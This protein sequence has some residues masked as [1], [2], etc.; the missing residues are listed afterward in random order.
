MSEFNFIKGTS[1]LVATA[2][3]DGHEVR[4]ELL[5][6]FNLSSHERLR[7]EDPFTAEMS[8][9]ADNRITVNYSR[10]QADLNRDR[11]NAVYQKPED[12]WGLQ[13]WKGK[14]SSQHV[15][16]SLQYYDRFYAALKAY[17]DELLTQHPRLIIYDIHTYNHRREAYDKYASV[18]ENPELN[19]GTGNIVG[20]EWRNTIDAFINSA[21][22]FNYEGRHLDVRENVKFAGGYFSKWLGETYGNK[23]CPIA[24]EFKKFF[25]DEWTGEG[26]YYQIEHLKELLAYTTTSVLEAAEGID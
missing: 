12:A 7:E 25:M 1:N 20:E 17:L 18:E 8:L 9:I 2:I 26:D 19:L 10:F 22:E 6:H 11:K 3:H 16:E 4:P 21:R 14:L 5:S 23:V 24:I 15:E 13:V